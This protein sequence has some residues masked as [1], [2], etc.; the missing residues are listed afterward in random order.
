MKIYVITKGCYSDYHICAVTEDKEKAEIL[1]EKFTDIWDI[2]YIEEFDTEKSEEVLK[3]NNVYLCK[4]YLKFDKVDV[5]KHSWDNMS[6]DDYQVKKCPP[7]DLL[8]TFVN[9]NDEQDA[10]KIASDKFAKYR[11]EKMNL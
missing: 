11:A 10:L 2:A 9:A 5:Y 1:K 3:W 8:A 6:D 7:G 4:Y